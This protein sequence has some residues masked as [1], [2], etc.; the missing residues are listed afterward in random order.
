M[1][2]TQGGVGRALLSLAY[3]ELT[4]KSIEANHAGA[5]SCRAFESSWRECDTGWWSS[6]NSYSRQTSYEQYHGVRRFLTLTTAEL[7]SGFLYLN[8]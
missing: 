5:F 2:T 6:P 7:M 8:L 1:G 3:V 4:H